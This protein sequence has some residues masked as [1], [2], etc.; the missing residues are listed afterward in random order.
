MHLVASKILDFWFKKSKSIQWFKKD[1]K[2]DNL[3]KNNFLHHHNAAI[4]GDF[5]SW[6]KSP[7]ESLAFIILLDQFSRNI[8]RN[9]HRSFMFD[10]ISL[11]FCKYGINK[12]FEAKLKTN[13]HKLFYI[14]P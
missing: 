11:D 10:H 2:Y 5:I 7:Y 6:K 9:D 1:N 4:N 12:S 14:L 3:I 8:Y 13:D